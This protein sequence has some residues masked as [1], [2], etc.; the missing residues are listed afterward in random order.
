MFPKIRPFWYI[1]LECLMAL[2]NFLDNSYALARTIFILVRGGFQP[3][4][5]AG[6]YAVGLSS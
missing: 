1:L 5:P 6:E 2:I 4:A 3:P